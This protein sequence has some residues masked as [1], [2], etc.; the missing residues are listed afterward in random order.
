[1]FKMPNSD[2]FKMEVMSALYVVELNKDYTLAS[3]KRIQKFIKALE[4][5]CDNCENHKKNMNNYILFFKW[6]FNLHSDLLHDVFNNF[7]QFGLKEFK[8]LRPSLLELRHLYDVY[9]TNFSSLS[10]NMEHPYRIIEK[11]NIEEKTKEFIPE[12]THLRLYPSDN[13]NRSYL[14]HGACLYLYVYDFAQSTNKV[15]KNLLRHKKLK[16]F[17]EKEKNNL[18]CLHELLENE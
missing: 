7:K 12:E 1:L 8:D 16:S 4:Q 17:F 9:M 11:G 6:T 15:L 5:S 10:N 14:N 18:S 2:P 13:Y 3:Y